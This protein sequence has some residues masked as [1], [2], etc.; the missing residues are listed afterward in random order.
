MN[1]GTKYGLQLRAPQPTATAKK[2]LPP[3]KKPSIFDQD[4]DDEDNVEQ[5]IARQAAKNRALKEVEFQHKAALE[6]DSTAFAY[7]EVYDDL[8][9]TSATSR[10]IERE[11]GKPKYITKLLEK[12]KTRQ[13]EQE[14]IYERKLLKERK[15]EDHLYGDKD[16]FVTSAYKKKLAEQEKW[17]EEERLRELREQADEVT[18]K[19]DLSDFYHN[20]LSKNVAF[21]AKNKVAQQGPPRLREQESAEAGGPSPISDLDEGSEPVKKLQ[22]VK[23]S[24][25]E[26]KEES[27]ERLEPESFSVSRNK[28]EPNADGELQH[29]LGRETAEEVAS[30]KGECKQDGSEKVVS[31]TE[32][33]KQDGSEKDSASGQPNSR[34]IDRKPTEDALAT[35]KERFLA[36]K[37]MRTT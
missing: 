10:A 35:A 34:P 25:G 9:A 1:R 6:Q 27:G 37:R 28:P 15:L 33:R 24:V 8:K 18:N 26:N 17:L 23:A 3:P 14:I 19:G 5:A 31:G 4:D 12:A 30:G 36:R 32:E 16:K 20:L 22:V 7:D 13:Q 11:Q 21:G 29:G 2:A